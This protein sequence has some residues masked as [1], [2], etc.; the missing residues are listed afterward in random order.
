MERN[1]SVNIL[2]EGVNDTLSNF[3]E[4]LEINASEDK[5]TLLQLIIKKITIKNRKDIE[6]VALHFDE[7]VQKYFINNKK[8]ESSDDGDSSFILFIIKV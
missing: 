1:D 8:G 3:H 5:K 6:G 4:L 2:Y 7:K